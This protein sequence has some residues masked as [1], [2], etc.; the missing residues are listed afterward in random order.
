MIIITILFQYRVLLL[1]FVSS[2]HH[3]YYS[4]QVIRFSIDYFLQEMAPR[5]LGAVAHCLM[6]DTYFVVIIG[7]LDVQAFK[8][9]AKRRMKRMKGKKMIKSC[10]RDALNDHLDL[11]QRGLVDGHDQ[12]SNIALHCCPTCIEVS[13]S[14]SWADWVKQ[15][16]SSGGC[17]IS[18]CEWVLFDDSQPPPLYLDENNVHIPVPSS[19]LPKKPKWILCSGVGPQALELDRSKSLRLY[20][21]S[22]G[23]FGVESL[24]GGAALY[25]PLD[26][27]DAAMHR[28]ACHLCSKA[29]VRRPLE[30]AKI[31]RANVPVFGAWDEA[32]VKLNFD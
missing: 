22:L 28:R 24:T 4:F 1:L 26:G 20:K 31:L 14:L 21:P 29:F 23:R 16:A 15:N 17:V 7:I 3:H 2:Y 11:L 25:E 10:P 5:E 13:F 6:C 18:P 8:E 30:S 19:E 12:A 27:M 32:Q 9:T